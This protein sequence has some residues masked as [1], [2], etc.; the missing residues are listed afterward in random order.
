MTGNTLELGAVYKTDETGFLSRVIAFDVKMTLCDFWMTAESA[1]S[2][3]NSQLKT[4]AYT[5]MDS[6]RLLKQG[7]YIRTEAL[8]DDEYRLH[9]PDLPLAFAQ[10][11]QFSWYEILPTAEVAKEKIPLLEIPE[12]YLLPY[13]PKLSVKPFVLV[14]AKN[15]KSFT[16]AELLDLAWHVQK[17]HLRE[18]RITNGVGLYRSGLRHRTP[19][20][21]IWGSTS[22]LE[23]GPRL[24]ALLK[25]R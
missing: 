10:F 12:I 2:L 5:A 18:T 19:S 13:G 6:Q 8:T 3:Q 1:W 7:A 23:D 20:Y 11:E 4:S 9:R 14:K 25:K 22:L 21:Y 16:T 17:P 15:G 24:M